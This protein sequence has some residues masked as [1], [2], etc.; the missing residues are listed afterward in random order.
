MP[1]SIKQGKLAMS[2]SKT[3][4]D[5]SGISKIIENDVANLFDQ[6]GLNESTNVSVLSSAVPKVIVNNNSHNITELRPITLNSSNIV[7]TSTATNLLQ[8]VAAYLKIETILRRH[9]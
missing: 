8:T 2:T 7:G 5:I 3:N 1:S 9:L 4:Q 6:N